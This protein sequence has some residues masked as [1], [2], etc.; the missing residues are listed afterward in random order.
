MTRRRGF[1]NVRRLASGRWQARYWLPGGGHLAA[2]GTFATK[3]EATKWLATV[4]ADQAR[5]LWVDPRAGRVSLEQ[6]ASTWLDS[7]VGISPRTREIYD[8]QLRLHVLP[9][10]SDDVPALGSVPIADITPELVRAWYVGLA[11]QRGAS[12]AAKAYTRLRQ[13]LGQAVDDDRIAKNPCRIKKGAAE[14]H[15]E[16][17][18]ASL[19]ELYELAGAVPE[20][21]RTL[22]L[23]AGLAG[24][25]Q[26]ELL[27]LRR[28]DVD[29]LRGTVA[30][31]RKRLRLASGLVI[32]DDPKSE[33][34]RRRVALP[35]PLVAELDRHHS[36]YVGPS[37]DAY[38][39]TTETPRS[40]PTTSGPGYGTLP[41]ARS[42]SPASGSTTFATPPGPWPPGQAPRPRS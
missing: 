28:R 41:P 34:G 18:F 11:A 3:A 35:A 22:V 36:A 31:H 7:K 13:V 5:G 37:A 19:A 20:R 40:T 6:Y 8:L 26:G 30:V 38:V 24:L 17:R 15:P 4:E 14:R 10:V 42:A 25:R 16:Q 32:E 12:V 21:Y 9:A 29:I 27:A 23:T 2:P 1:G 39:F 33:A